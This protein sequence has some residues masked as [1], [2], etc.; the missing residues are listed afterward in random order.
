MAL[1]V[2]AGLL[3]AVAALI[4][5]VLILPRLRPPEGVVRAVVLVTGPPIRY[6]LVVAMVW[7]AWVVSREGPFLAIL[8]G[9]ALVLVIPIAAIALGTLMYGRR[10]HPGA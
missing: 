8:A 4:V 5:L 3:V 7:Y 1:G 6:A 10:E 9:L 2:M